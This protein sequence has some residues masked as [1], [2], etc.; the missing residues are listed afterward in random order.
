MKIQIN[1]LMKSYTGEIVLDELSLEIVKGSKC[2]IV[3][4]NGC[5]K[6]T[7]LKIIAGIEN[8]QSGDVFIPK[9]MSIGYMVQVFPSYKETSRSFILSSFHHYQNYYNKIKELEYKMANEEIDEHI[10]DEYAKVYA[11]FE[12]AGGYDLENSL[13]AYAKGLGIDDVLEQSFDTLSGGQKTRIILVQLLLENHEVLCLDEPTNHL[14]MD[15]IEWLENYC[16]TTNKTLILVSHD[17]Q[18]LMNVVSVFYE[19]EDGMVVTYHGNYDQYRVQRHERFL[20]LVLNYEEQQKEIQKIKLAIRRYRQWGHE[21]DNED[22]FKRAKALEKRLDR[23]EKLPKPIEIRNKLTFDLKSTQVG[24][25][26]VVIAKDFVIGYDTP[27]CEEMNFT[28][29][30]KERVAIVAPN[31]TGKTTLFKTLLGLVLPYSGEITFG[32]TVDVGYLPQ[33]IQF[34]NGSER[35]LDYFIRVCNLEEEKARRYLAWFGFY[36]VDMYRYISSFSGGEQVRMKLL[37]IMLKGC[38]CILLDEPTNHLDLLS[39]EIIENVLTKFEGTIIVISH[40]RL[41]L[42]NLRVRTIGLSSSV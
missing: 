16:K 33:I 9:E 40:D 42:Q 21:G 3:G 31:G 18:F 29:Q 41:F 28:I 12:H 6:S 11:K 38:N 1:N 27:L 32:Q 37:E 34:E 24:S 2:A 23:I 20:K 5:G 17:R 26:D 7:L 19:I 30:R 4:E 39:C 14:D 36:Q 25:K 8:Y 15:G 22:F 13:E 10:L 35:I